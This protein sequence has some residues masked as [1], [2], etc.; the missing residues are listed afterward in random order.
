MQKFQQDIKRFSLRLK[1]NIVT[2]W[3]K[4][5]L[6]IH[7]YFFKWIF[8]ILVIIRL[9]INGFYENNNRIFGHI[10]SYSYGL[11]VSASNINL[12]L[13]SSQQQIPIDLG[14][15][16]CCTLRFRSFP[17]PMIRA[18]FLPVPPHSSIAHR[19]A[20]VALPPR[21]VNCHHPMRFAIKIRWNGNIFLTTLLA[22]LIA[23]T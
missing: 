1:S 20:Q 13:F 15:F 7:K 21:L 22:N 16:L 19:L 14:S 12:N 23:K 2:F 9:F 18:S 4:I 5:V 6:L 11:L 8:E 10:I 3:T 17:F